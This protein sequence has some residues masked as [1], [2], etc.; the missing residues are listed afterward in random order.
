MNLSDQIRIALSMLLYSKD[1]LPVDSFKIVTITNAILLLMKTNNYLSEE[2]FKELYARPSNSFFIVKANQSEKG[3]DKKPSDKIL[4]KRIHK[5]KPE[6][7]P[8][9][10]REEE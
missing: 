7:N 10:N 6:P 1:A 5:Y 4:R 3:S 8:S 9:N 2:Q